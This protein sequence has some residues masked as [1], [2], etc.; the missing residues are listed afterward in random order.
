MTIDITWYVKDNR[1]GP[2]AH[3][4]QGLGEVRAELEALYRPYITGHRQEVSRIELLQHDRA[5]A[6]TE[7]E[8]SVVESST[9]EDGYK[10]RSVVGRYLDE[11]IWTNTTQWQIR[12]R[13]VEYTVST[14]YPQG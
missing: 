4:I 13:T 9:P 1:K 6:V 2:T 14:N 11:L 5:L 12:V 8:I 10:G 7:F 3:M